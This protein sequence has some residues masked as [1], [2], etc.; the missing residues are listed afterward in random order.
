MSDLALFTEI[1]RHI[2][3]CFDDPEAKGKLISDAVD[4]FLGQHSGHVTWQKLAKNSF[5][6]R[7]FRGVGVI[8]AR[9]Y[10]AGPKE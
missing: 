1:A 7:L 4:F 8:I 6:C 10:L 2:Q 9:D 3:R 5:N